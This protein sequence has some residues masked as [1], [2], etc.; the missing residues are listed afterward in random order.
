MRAGSTPAAAWRLERVHHVGLTVSDIERS[1]AFYRDILGMTLVR[2]RPRVDADYVARQTGYSGV[3]L[4][5][6]SLETHEG[7]PSIELAQY[8]TR[9]GE[10]LALTTNQPGSS[11]LCLIVTDLNACHA[12]LKTKGV[13]FT[14]EPISI[15]AGPNNGGLVVYLSDPDGHTIEL[16]QPPRT[17]D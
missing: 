2:H 6:A 16:F 4:S 14:S 3:E 5:V 7:G 8:L 12:G 1:I 9:Q 10:A 15:T 17:A 11:H 13:E